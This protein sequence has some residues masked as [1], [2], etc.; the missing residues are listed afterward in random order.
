MLES[1]EWGLPTAPVIPETTIGGEKPRENPRNSVCLRESS[2][3]T[4]VQGISRRQKQFPL[5]FYTV[6][7]HGMP[8]NPVLPKQILAMFFS[9]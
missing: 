2:K 1:S 9:C 3:S 6:M 7:S 4:R 8:L 5:K